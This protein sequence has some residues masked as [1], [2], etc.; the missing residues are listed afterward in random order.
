MLQA[1]SAFGV[2][3]NC[4]VAI[5]II[6]ESANHL[7]AHGKHSD[8]VAV[9]GDVYAAA[10]A[11]GLYAFSFQCHLIFIPV[12][13]TLRS[14]SVRTMGCVIVSAYTLCFA[15]YLACGILG[16]FAYGNAV[17]TA[18][19]DILADNLPNNALA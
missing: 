2:F 17:N 14:R 13:W 12:Y 7:A 3:T 6:Y 18:S 16:Y 9:T 8:V 11:F 5:V 19:G 15:V 10:S 4:F 1:T